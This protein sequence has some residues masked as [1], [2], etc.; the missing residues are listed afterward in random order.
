MTGAEPFELRV[1]DVMDVPLRG[2]LLRL[3]L[4]SGKPRTADIAVGRKLTVKA[5]NGAEQ[6]VRIVAHSITGGNVS[7]DRLDRVR[8]LDIVVTPESDE[9]L[10]P[11]DFGNTVRGPVSE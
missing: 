9:E 1:S 10:R 2:L 5:V 4:V 3:K 11:I 6:T 8:E 7:Q